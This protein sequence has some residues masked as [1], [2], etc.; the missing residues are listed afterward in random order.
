MIKIDIEFYYLEVL[1][2]IIILR[3]DEVFID[4]GLDIFVYNNLDEV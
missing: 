2:F 3:D 4:V 1:D